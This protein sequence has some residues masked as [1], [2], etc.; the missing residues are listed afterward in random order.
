[1]HV[2]FLLRRRYSTRFLESFKDA[3]RNAKAEG[4]EKFHPTRKSFN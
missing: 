3:R 1:M 2:K 4:K